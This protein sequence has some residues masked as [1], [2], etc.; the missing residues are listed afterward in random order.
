MRWLLLI[1]LWILCGGSPG[2]GCIAEN[3]TTLSLSPMRERRL[4][5]V[6]EHEDKEEAYRPTHVGRRMI[7]AELTNRMLAPSYKVVDIY[8]FLES[9]LQ[10][11]TDFSDEL[12]VDEWVKLITKAEAGRASTMTEQQARMIF[13][14]VDAKGD[15]N[16]SIRDLVPIVFGKA[17]KEQTKLILRVLEGEVVQKKALQQQ[18]TVQQN[19]VQLGGKVVPVASAGAG[20]GAATATSGTLRV[21]MNMKDETSEQVVVRLPVQQLGK[22]KVIKL[23]VV[24]FSHGMK[25]ANHRLMV[26]REEEGTTA[27]TAGAPSTSSSVSAKAGRKALCVPVKLTAPKRKDVL[28]INLRDLPPTDVK[29]QTLHVRLSLRL[30][31]NKKLLNIKPW[32]E[33]KVLNYDDAVRR[34]TTCTQA[35]LP[36]DGEAM[37]IAHLGKPVMMVSASKDA[38]VRA[39][40]YAGQNFGKMDEIIV[41]SSAL[42]GSH[43]MGLLKFASVRTEDASASL[44]LTVRAGKLSGHGSQELALCVHPG[45]WDENDVAFKSFRPNTRLCLY[46]PLASTIPGSRVCIAVPRK[47]FSDGSLN[48]QLLM[49]NNIH[50]SPTSEEQ[51]SHDWV[52]FYSR[53]HAFYDGP[54]IVYGEH[55]CAALGIPNLE[56]L[57]RAEDCSFSADSPDAGDASVAMA[58]MPFEK[59][60]CYVPLQMV[61]ELDTLNKGKTAL[62]Y[63][64]YDLSIGGG[65]KYFLEV[66]AFLMAKGYNVL[67]ATHDTNYCQDK[68]CVLRT[69]FALRVHI[70]GDF[71]Y[72]PVSYRALKRL[73]ATRFDVY[74]EMGNTRFPEFR[75]PAVLG[76]YQ[77]QFPF[78]LDGPFSEQSVLRLSTFN[79]VI[80]NSRFTMSWYIKYS[81]PALKVMEDKNMRYPAIE[82]VNPPVELE[83]GIK[84]RPKKRDLKRVKIVQL[85]RV[86]SGRQNKGHKESI[87]AIVALNANKTDN[88]VYELTIIG[89]IHPG[90]EDYAVSL[91]EMAKGH[92]VTFQFGIPGNELMKLLDEGDMIWHLTGVDI[93]EENSD[94]A[95]YE[96]F[97]IS[98]VEGMS[99]GLVPVIY[100]KGG[101]TEIPGRFGYEVNN[102][103]QLIERTQHAAHHRYD[104]KETAAMVEHVQQFS[105]PAFVKRLNHVIDRAQKSLYFNA[106]QLPRLPFTCATEIPHDNSAIGTAFIFIHSPGWHIKMI[107]RNTMYM[108]GPNWKLAIAYPAYM[109]DYIRILM[110][111]TMGLHLGQTKLL[112]LDIQVSNTDA[113]RYCNT[114]PLSGPAS[115]PPV[116]FAL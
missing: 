81:T 88:V 51:S 5:A 68:Q 115:A 102:V 43:R 112:P 74:Y 20:A 48:L 107:L 96:H 6:A 29:G 45:E 34:S 103:G 105:K 73:H 35:P 10:V 64:P 55:A 83:T 93:T 92:P 85:G 69:A 30:H 113:Y 106:V 31:V 39:G 17:N 38:H 61:E 59:D 57:I 76:M 111:N 24:D 9:F 87:T 49:T 11:D 110:D 27:M 37:D 67:L 41:K 79:L 116:L 16:L 109:E 100:S 56:S 86:F 52:S 18:K 25:H 4:A 70:P 13:Q 33:V 54:T 80:V 104:A 97:G 82:V 72:L 15:G 108:L 21:G 40:Q 62:I 78:D 42:L 53:E 8:T 71:K 7:G 32:L 77:C 1:A 58:S 14:R 23:K 36:L 46:V 114:T 63:T 75:N 91:Q 47:F 44:V 89:N 99:H 94:P 95:S 2:Y 84:P 66:M 28:C 50:S 3:R 12:D 101:V 98:V 60:V 90:F 65:E 19:V 22:N 26:C